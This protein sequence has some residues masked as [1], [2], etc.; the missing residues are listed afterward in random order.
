MGR[1]VA[2]AA[3]AGAALLGFAG[4]TLAQDTLAPFSA[5][6]TADW[7]SI[8]VGTS[9]LKLERDGDNGRYVYTW[10]VAARGVFRVVHHDDVVQ[11]S[12]L[13]VEGGHARPIKYRGTEGSASVDLDFD[14]SGGRVRGTSEGKPVDF[15]LADGMQD[16]LSIQIEM[17]LDVKNGNLAKTFRIVDKDQPKD[18]IYTEEGK[19]S[20][21]TA[22][23]QLD[24]IVVASRRAGNN[25]ILRMWLAPSLGYV[26]V[27][28][29]RSRD[30]KLEFAMRI[31]SLK[32]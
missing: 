24:T 7:K 5:H 3:L 26:P 22:L 23:G 25:R 27:Q 29:E 1:R 21:R 4:R 20:I 6:Y 18:F 2:A 8:N 13:R 28:A 14:W 31:Q 19:A 11:T 9:D 10:T 32:R 15:E 17:M 12:W 30:G 16:V